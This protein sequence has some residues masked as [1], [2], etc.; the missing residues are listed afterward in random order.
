MNRKSN[1]QAV[2]LTRK[3]VEALQRL[4]EQESKRSELGITPS[5]HEVARR[6]MDKV[7]SKIVG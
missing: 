1:T 6:L 7:L 5:I 4:R 3:Q 2:L